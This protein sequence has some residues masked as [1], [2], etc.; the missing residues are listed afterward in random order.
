M[1]LTLA[2][3]VLLDEN[4]H[5]YLLHRNKKGI[6]QWELPGGKVEP[7]E[8]AEQAAVRELQE[9][10]G[11]TVRLIKKLGET[12]FEENGT[13]HYYTWFLA[14]VKTGQLAIR[15]P[16]T[17]DNLKSFS[18]DTLSSIKLSNNMKNLYDALLSDE[19]RLS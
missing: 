13:K 17:F 18:L 4:Q 1:S 2:G 9:E 7:N 11:V 8:A 6:T 15:E 12:D 5:I 14:E 19:V 3:C 16:E 10:L